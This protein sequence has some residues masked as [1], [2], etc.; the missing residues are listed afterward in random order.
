MIP[1]LVKQAASNDGSTSMTDSKQTSGYL[2]QMN[3]M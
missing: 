2:Q 3:D 1:G